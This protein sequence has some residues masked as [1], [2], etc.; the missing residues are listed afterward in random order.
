MKD[1]S[2]RLIGIVM[3]TES[4]EKRK[5]LGSKLIQYGIDN[6]YKKIFAHK[7]RPIDT[8]YIPK[9]RD[10]EIEVYPSRGFSRI[11]RYDDYIDE[12]ILI[13]EKIK[14]P[15]KKGDKIGKLVVSIDGHILEEIDLIV[16]KDIKKARIFIWIARSIKDL[17]SKIF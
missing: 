16:N 10:K 7:D 3:G 9:S 2:F 13:D 5:E 15:L 12:D 14:L 11:V 17:L 1:E 4:E 6:Y 8:L